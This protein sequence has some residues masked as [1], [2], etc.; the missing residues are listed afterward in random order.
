MVFLLSALIGAPS[1]LWKPFPGVVH[2]VSEGTLFTIICLCC[3]FVDA[4]GSFHVVRQC[5]FEASFAFLEY[6]HLTD[7]G[8]DMFVA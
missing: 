5:S 3:E 6:R 4:V 1:E 2:N 8:W 7:T